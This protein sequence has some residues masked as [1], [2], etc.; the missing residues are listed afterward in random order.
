MN[1]PVVLNFFFGN[2]TEVPEIIVEGGKVTINGKQ[3][4]IPQAKVSGKLDTTKSTE[5][6]GFDEETIASI[7]D[8]IKKGLE[9]LEELEASRKK[10]PVRKPKFSKDTERVIKKWNKEGLVVK[11]YDDVDF[12]GYEEVPP[13]ESLAMFDQINN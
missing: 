9:K 6:L 5:S 7:K 1:S 2:Q 4:Q 12:I 10:K 8:S 3:I 11:N 13:K